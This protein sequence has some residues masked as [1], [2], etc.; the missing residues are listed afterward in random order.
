VK[1]PE[2]NI[3]IDTPITHPELPT[4][5]ACAKYLVEF[6]KALRPVVNDIVPNMNTQPMQVR[7]DSIRCRMDC[8]SLCA[9][10]QT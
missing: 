3:T 8:A 7:R 4:F 10:T 9:A 2:I 6:A 5:A 1:L